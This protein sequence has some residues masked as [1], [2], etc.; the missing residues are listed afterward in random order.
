MSNVLINLVVLH[1]KAFECFIGI[2][3]CCCV[4]KCIL[5]ICSE[6]VPEPFISVC[7]GWWYPCCWVSHNC[8]SE[9]VDLFFNPSVY[10]PSSDEREAQGNPLEWIDHHLCSI[11]NHPP[12]LDL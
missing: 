3:F 4:L 11:I 6:G 10:S 7:I 8:S 5:E 12:D 2:L 1:G 9:L